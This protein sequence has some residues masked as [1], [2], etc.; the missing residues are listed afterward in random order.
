M[1]NYLLQARKE[2]GYHS[3]HE[4]PIMCLPVRDATEGKITA[5]YN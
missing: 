5:E 2:H 3:L 1:K 4:I